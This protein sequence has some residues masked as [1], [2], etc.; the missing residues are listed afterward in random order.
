V[1]P[2]ILTGE[3]A[4]TV[5]TVPLALVHVPPGVV[6]ENIV[7]AFSQIVFVPVMALGVVITVN[8][9]V[10]LQLPSA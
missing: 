4:S 8:E 9:A 2:V 1:I 10:V 6:V 7:V 5:A 3:D